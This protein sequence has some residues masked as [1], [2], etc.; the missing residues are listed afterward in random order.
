MNSKTLFTAISVAMAF[1]LSCSEGGGELTDSRDSKKYKTV[2]IG[3]QIWMAENLNF[4]AK[5]SKCYEDKPENCEKYG[6]LYNWETAKTACPSG[7]HLPNDKEWQTLVDFAGGDKVAGGKLKAASGWDDSGD[8]SGNGTDEY[9]FSA[10]PGGGYI[11]KPEYY[12]EGFGNAGNAGYWWSSDISDA[13]DLPESEC[14]DCVYGLI[15]HREMNSYNG[16]IGGGMG[17]GRT[18]LNSVRCVK[19]SNEKTSKDSKSLTDSRDGKS[20][21]IAKIGKQTWMAENLNLEVKGSECYDKKPDNC[22]KYGRLYNWNAANQVCPEGWHL[23]SSEEWQTLVDFAGGEL[24]AGAK[25]KAKSGWNKGEW[26]KSGDGTDNYGFS[27]LPGGFGSTFYHIGNYG[28][29]WSSTESNAKNARYLAIYN[30]FEN[31]YKMEMAKVAT[32][33]VRCVMD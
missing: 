7:W 23:P 8:K 21:K 28:N 6:R 11:F 26:D 1:T 3:K 25:L 32:F 24:K 20:Y 18:T 33:S 29:W 9:G 31:V 16:E 12:D 4:D 14:E 15:H 27:A 30:T 17:S 22:A 10:L 19:G 13:K 2:K 5:G